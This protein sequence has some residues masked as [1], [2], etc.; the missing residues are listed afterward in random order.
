MHDSITCPR[1]W[2]DV[3]EMFIT[4]YIQD[5]YNASD[6]LSDPETK[7]VFIRQYFM[8]DRPPIHCKRYHRVNTTLL[9]V[10]IS[11]N[12]QVRSCVTTLASSVSTLMDRTTVFVNKDSMLSIV[13][14]IHLD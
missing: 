4:S 1:C 14:E 11:M 12:A 8:V 13:Q 7:A 6:P 2:S 9:V 3:L 5:N 10:Q